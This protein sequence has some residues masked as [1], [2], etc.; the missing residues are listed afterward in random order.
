MKKS[1]IATIIFVASLS[2]MATY[3]IANTFI[4]KNSKLTMSVP[5]AEPLPPSPKDIQLSKQFFNENSLNPTVEVYVQN[6]TETTPENGLS[7]TKPDDAKNTP[8]TN[9]DSTTS[10]E[11]KQ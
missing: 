3:F 11:T 5:I 8:D 9:A 1:E 10:N 2:M 7:T 6:G 4:G